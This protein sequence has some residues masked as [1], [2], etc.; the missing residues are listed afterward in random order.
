M[1][2]SLIVTS[3]ASLALAA[4]PVVGAFAATSRVTDE[5]E[6]TIAKECAITS[7]TTDASD[8]IG[9]GTV[10]ENKYSTE[11]QNGE[12]KVLG[13]AAGT[14]SA[15][16]GSS[17]INVVCNDSATTGTATSWK[18]EA[19]GGDGTT[20]STVLA[21]AGNGSGAATNIA[22]GTTFGGEN[23]A[24]AMQVVGNGVT[25][26]GGF[27]SANFHVVPGETTLVAEGNG[28][29][30]GAFT[31]SYKV[32]ISDTQAADTYTGHVTYTLTNP[33]A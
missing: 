33:N 7:N 11:M 18:L 20:V 2:K 8:G 29:A 28:S 30:A 21:G 32:Y 17:V 6:V 16:A 15:T 4:M 14:G 10:T 5:I 13:G 27:D 25:I 1:K 23:S 19:V 26:Q 9:D 3:A 12:T 31:M 24:W 22:T